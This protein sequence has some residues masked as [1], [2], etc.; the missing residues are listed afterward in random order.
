MIRLC[1]ALA[2]LCAACLDFHRGPLPNEPK[3]ATFAT[4]DDARIRYVDVGTGPAV[5][6]IHGFGASL[7][8]WAPVIPVLAKQ[9]RVLALDLK[10]FGWSDR[11]DGDYSLAAQAH[12][13]LA[14]M[15]ERGIERAAIVGQSWGAAV[16]LSV[17]A[18]APDRVTR[19]ALYDGLAFEDQVSSFMSWARVR[20]MGKLMFWLM[21]DGSLL[22]ENAQVAFYDKSIVTADHLD[23]IQASMDRPGATAAAY[24]V[25]HQLRLV[26][27]QQRYRTMTQPFLLLWGRED[28][29]T[30]RRFGER[31]A[32]ELPNAK[33][34]VYPRCGHLPQVEAPHST[35]DLAA[36]LAEDAS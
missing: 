35:A 36:F 4:V 21:W 14:L 24:S 26:E 27:L 34:I 9:H 29:I 15:T 19:V 7:E 16:A 6:L 25:V 30:P 11:P 28:Q 3:Q 10:G 20:G 17:V 5:V 22:S 33:M 2:L 12:L 32:R 13:V 23:R 1:I 31:L 8:S 18:A